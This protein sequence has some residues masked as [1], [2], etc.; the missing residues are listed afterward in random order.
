MMN[1]TVCCHSGP[2]LSDE[3]W[4]SELRSQLHNESLRVHSQ[5]VCNDTNITTCVIMK[6]ET[7]YL[8]H[9]FDDEIG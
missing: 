6:E 2:V 3:G 5:R 8:L 9:A 4:T 7:L 1:Q